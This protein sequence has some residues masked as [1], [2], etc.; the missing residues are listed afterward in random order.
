MR[1]YI[2]NLDDPTKRSR[3]CSRINQL[4]GLYRIRVT[5]YKPKRSDRQNRYYWSIFVKSFADFLRD[6]GEAVTD[7]DAHEY[8]KHKF[9]R[10]TITAGGE[11]QDI[12]RSTTDLTTAEFNTYLDQCAAWLTDM[13]G[14]VLPA[15]GEY[16]E[17]AG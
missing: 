7:N 14:I 9:L 10:K 6:Q 16:R 17:K 12:T 15:P 13:F 11:R 2:V 8:L 3:V 5:K 1:D 4:R